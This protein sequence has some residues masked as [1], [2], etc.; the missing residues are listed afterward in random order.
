MGICYISCAVS[1]RLDFTPKSGDL[2][3]GAD[4]GYL[5]LKNAKIKPN[6]VIGDFDSY[7]GSVDCENIIRLPKIKD[8][9]DG[10]VAIKYA[11]EQGYK[12]IYMYGA[13][14][15]ALDHTIAN[16]AHLKGYSEKGVNLVLFDG[17]NVLFAVHNGRISFSENSKGRISIFSATEI[18]ENVSLKGLF[19]ELNNETLYSSVPLGVSNEFVGKKAEVSVGNGTLYLYT[20]KEN[21]EN[22]LTSK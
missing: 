8:F 21:F 6:V 2:V 20:S 1:T 11:I 13:I 15:G 9:T 10:E 12:T 18:S 7:E 17:D 14:G 16:I 22:V 4:K 19:Y 5:N 3:I